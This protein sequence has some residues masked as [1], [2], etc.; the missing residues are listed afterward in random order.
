MKE[1]LGGPEALPRGLLPAYLVRCPDP[2]PASL[3]PRCPGHRPETP[4]LGLH[5]HFPLNPLHSLLSHLRAFAH[6][7]VVSKIGLPSPLSRLIPQ[8][9]LNICFSE[10][11]PHPT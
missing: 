5:P 7:I 11:L 3:R 4:P 10:I 6:A 9:Q 8:I 1:N 2:A